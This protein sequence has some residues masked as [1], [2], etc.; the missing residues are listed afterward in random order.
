M[1]RFF[2]LFFIV[3]LISVAMILVS[4]GTEEFE[5]PVSEEFHEHDFE[6]T[7]VDP[8]CISI[9][10]TEHKCECGYVFRDEF[11]TDESAHDFNDWKVT[12]N[13]TCTLKK[14]EQRDCK[15][16]GLIQT[17][18]GNTVSHNFSIFVEEVP[19]TCT[20]NGHIINKCQWC[21]EINKT[22]LTA[23]HIWTAWTVE[24]PNL[25]PYGKCDIGLEIRDCTVCG[26]H[27]EREL[28]PH[29]FVAVKTIA[30]TCTTKGYTVYE[31]SHCGFTYFGSYQ[32]ATGKHTF[33]K[34]KDCTEYEGYEVRSCS[35]CGK[36][37]FQL[38]EDK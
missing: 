2:S 16:C 9:G 6:S 24:I 38:K 33:S 14:K 19:Y 32:N 28:A 21:D 3:A 4:C 1:K 22:T 17:K 13:P 29:N 26:A 36:T 25:D 18:E 12:V 27:E 31:C 10:Y 15:T 23:K 5:H 30:A 8:T 35:V 37:E 11:I 34:W 7:V 20:E